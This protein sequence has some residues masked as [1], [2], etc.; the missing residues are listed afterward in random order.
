[1]M[2]LPFIWDIRAIKNRCKPHGQKNFSKKFLGKI[3]EELLNKFYEEFQEKNLK[4]FEV[5]CPKRLLSNSQWSFWNSWK[6]FLRNP[7]RNF[8][9]N[10]QCI[11][12]QMKGE[13]FGKSVGNSC[14]LTIWEIRCT[15]EIFG[16]ICAGFLRISSWSRHLDTSI[17]KPWRN[18]CRY[19]WRNSR[20]NLEMKIQMTTSTLFWENYLGKVLARNSLRN[21]WN[22]N[23]RDSWRNFRK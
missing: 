2:N 22:Y 20:R 5:H 6:K 13:I 4:N 16:I 19:P 7:R 17:S 12:G 23:L 1:M 8:W 21:S 14:T 18:C 10:Y 11:F 3:F 9:M 15:F